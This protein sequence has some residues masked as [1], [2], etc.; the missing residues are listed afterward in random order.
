MIEL[1][2][3]HLVDWFQSFRTLFHGSQDPIAQ[4]GPN[5]Y[6]RLIRNNGD[7]VR[8][9][10]SW[11]EPESKTCCISIPDLPELESLW[12]ESIHR[13]IAVGPRDV[14]LDACHSNAT[15]T[16]WFRSDQKIYQLASQDIWA[17]LIPAII[18]QR[19]TTVEAARQ[20]NRL[21]QLSTS[22]PTAV[23]VGSMNTVDFHKI[24]IEQSRARTLANA[25]RHF[26]AI[27]RQDRESIE[28][29][30]TLLRSLSGVGPWT[31]AETLRR[32]H[33]W[34][35]AVSE[36]DFHV[37]RHF[38]YAMTGNRGGTDSEMLAILE[39]FRPY[40]ALVID[41]VLRHGKGPGKTG[42]GLRNIDIRRL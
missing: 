16:D 13:C 42:P 6:V 20:W 3:D 40:R 23:Q 4:L 11:S 28:I 34:V 37:A 2:V 15:L 14:L 29:A 7:L 39:Q 36:G 24:G 9:R 8:V 26:D 17:E 1:Q 32:S 41:S 18:G 21:A 25:A 33:G 5:E 12:A 30:Y 35:D 31:T 10:V 19:I 27:A 22:Y 38:V